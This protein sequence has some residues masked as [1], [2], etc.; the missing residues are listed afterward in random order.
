[1]IFQPSNLFLASIQTKQKGDLWRICQVWSGAWRA[2]T[3]AWWP[4]RGYGAMADS[5]GN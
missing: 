2:M 1:M 5:M 3:E 4:S